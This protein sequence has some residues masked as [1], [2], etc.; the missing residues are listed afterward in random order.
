MTKHYKIIVANGNY[1]LT[2]ACTS[3]AEAFGCIMELGNLSQKISF[4]PDEIMEALISMKH[5]KLISIHR[6]GFG[7]EMVDSDD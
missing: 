6:C 5:G 2:Y 7:V 1:P 4:D 3:C